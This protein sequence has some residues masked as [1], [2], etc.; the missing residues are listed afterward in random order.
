MENLS[1]HFQYVDAHEAMEFPDQHE[2]F[3]FASSSADPYSCYQ[4][5][6]TFHEA[7]GEQLNNTDSL[8]PISS[9]NIYHLGSYYSSSTHNAMSPHLLESLLAQSTDDSRDYYNS[10]Q[11]TSFT[12][13][14]SSIHF[15]ELQDSTIV[16]NPVQVPPNTKL[17]SMSDC[18]EISGTMFFKTGN[19]SNNFTNA[20]LMIEQGLSSGT[21]NYL[22][23]KVLV[24]NIHFH[25][26]N[27]LC[28]SF[29]DSP[30]S[31]RFARQD[32]MPKANISEIAK[33][34]IYGKEFIWFIYMAQNLPFALLY[35]EI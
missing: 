10:F 6:S 28:E 31:S 9:P 4:N 11:K 23:H 14:N 27:R 2:T 5:A 13:T 33:A 16:K 7:F 24:F 1:G 30:S 25:C 26:I 17:Q 3:S 12:V 18:P 21:M 29:A 32:S 20:H 19:Y 22:F 34:C 35:H 8:G 15:P